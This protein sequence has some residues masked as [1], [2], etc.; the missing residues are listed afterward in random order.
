MRKTLLTLATIVVVCHA[1]FAQGGESMPFMRIDRNPA[2]MGMAMAGSISGGSAAWSAYRNSAV[3]PFYEGTMDISLGYQLWAPKAVKT[4]NINFGGAYRISDK[5]GLSMGAVYQRGEEYTVYTDAGVADGTYN[6][7]EILFALGGGYQVAEKVSVG[8]NARFASQSLA[9]D[10][11]YSA[12]GADVNVLYNGGPYRVSVGVCNIG[13]SVTSDEGDSFS[14]PASVNLAGVYDAH[15]GEKSVL[16]AALDCDYY[17]ESGF[18]AAVGAQYGYNDMVFVRAGYHYGAEDA[19]FPS[20]ACI[21]LGGKFSGVR[22]DVA[23]LLAN[24]D[25]K[26]TLT[27]GLAYSF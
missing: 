3:L 7:S 15:F 20:F 12:F 25:L 18:T 16:E 23:Y 4:N 2:T 17:F 9:E 13:S 6:P 14:I 24:Q 11:T 5:F 8:V 26:N 10:K 21:G 27:L 19:I 1:A 22:I